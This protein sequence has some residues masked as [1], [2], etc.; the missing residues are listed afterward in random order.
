M[1]VIGQYLILC[2]EWFC[3]QLCCAGSHAILLAAIMM[4]VCTQQGAKAQTVTVQAQLETQP[5]DSWWYSSPLWNQFGHAVAEKQAMPDYKVPG[6]QLQFQVF[7]PA[8]AKAAWMALAVAQR[9]KS[10]IW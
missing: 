3:G 2:I 4:P 8:L 9:D 6:R 10:L 1:P 7:K 5:C